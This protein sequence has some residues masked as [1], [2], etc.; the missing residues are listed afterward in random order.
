MGNKRAFYHVFVNT[1]V[2]N[3][4]TSVLWWSLTFWIYLET[5]SVLVTA[6]L[7]GSYMILVAIVGV[8][9]GTYIDHHRKKRVMVGATLIASVAYT[10]ALVWFW[11]MPHE[12]LINIT[13]YGFWV[14]MALILCG[15]VVES[16][17]HI[18]MSTCVTLLVPLEDRDRMNALV[19]MGM[20]M[21]FAVTSVFSGLSIGLLGM[22]WSM[23]A[24]LALTV[25]ALIHVSGIDLPEPEIVH[26]TGGMMKVD[27]AGAFRAISEVPGLW[28]LIAFTTFNN[29]IAGVFMALLDPYGL[30]L[31]S[32]ELWG[33]LF[34]VLSFSFIIGGAVIAKVG[35]GS[36]PLRAMLLAN[37]LAWTIAG[38]FTIRESVWL[39]AVGL[40]VYMAVVPVIEAAEQTV[41]QAV[42][43]FEKQGRVFGF[44]QSVEVAAAPLTAFAIG[45]IAEFWLIPYMDSEA[46]RLRFGPL[47]GDGDA[48][49]IALVF[50]LAGAFGIAVT[51][52]AFTTP[53]Y[54]NLTERYAKI[55]L[56]S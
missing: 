49:G 30:T 50:L 36:R 41:M 8:P 4:A 48:R 33:L 7:G 26:V 42:V 3:L 44:A 2:T 56:G 28:G 25:L 45:P 21:G 52:F 22:G 14:L 38:G 34:G 16:A 32:V 12:A 39:L 18:A 51:I 54:R 5:R 1:V 13:S 24:A 27:F 11:V 46:G 55:R 15:A 17:R 43:P 19:G 6:I 47:L 23:I 53:A 31:V 20:G 29:L 35:L 10:L 9:F 40:F 37:L